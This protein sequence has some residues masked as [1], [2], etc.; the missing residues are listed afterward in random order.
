MFLN[1]L[2]DLLESGQ[3]SGDGVEVP[4]SS[5]HQVEAL[6]GALHVVARPQGRAN[7]V[8]ERTMEGEEGEEIEAGVDLVDVHGRGAE[9]SREE[10]PSNGGDGAIENVE[11]AAFT[12]AWEGG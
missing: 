5:P 8:D 10:T 4:G 11:D 2:G 9:A 3:G 12:L 6:Q 1:D 7:G